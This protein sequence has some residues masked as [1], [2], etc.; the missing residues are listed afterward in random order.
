MQTVI[1]ALIILGAMLMVVNIWN[2]IQFMH[3][4]RDVLLS[5][6]KR[7]VFWKY[8]ALVLLVFFLAGYLAPIRD[9]LPDLT[10]ESPD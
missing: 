1:M 9:T 2:Y 6:K 8:L 7:D 10:P 5:G 4:V 3:S